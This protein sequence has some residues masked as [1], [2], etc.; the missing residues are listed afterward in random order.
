LLCRFAKAVERLRGPS[1]RFA[2]LGMTAVS[3][4]TLLLVANH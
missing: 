3:K 2:C 1:A 4:S